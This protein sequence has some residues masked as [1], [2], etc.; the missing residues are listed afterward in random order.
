L[1]PD[2]FK[3]IVLGHFHKH[4][5]LGGLP[6][7]FYTGS[8]LQHSF[9][10]EGQHK[11]FYV[12]DTDK[13]WDVQFVQIPSPEFYTMT[14]YDVANEDMELLAEEGDYVRLQVT[15]KELESALSYLPENLKYKINLVKEYEETTRV[16]IK[17]GMS[18]EE[19]VTKYAQK[20][21]PDALEM[22][23]NIL[24]EVEGSR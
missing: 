11:G 18:F 15:D 22:G 19:I 24:R 3:Y 21:N 9:N 23:L 4:Q 14:A 13:R 2:K 7:V 6:H 5:F 20:Y 17:V 8:P 16:D 12:I 1:H 10:D